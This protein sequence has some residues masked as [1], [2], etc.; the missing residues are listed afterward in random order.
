MRWKITTS[1]NTTCTNTE[2]VVFSKSV[3]VEVVMRRRKNFVQEYFLKYHQPFLVQ[4]SGAIQRWGFLSPRFLSVLQVFPNSSS[5]FCNG[6]LLLEQFIL[7]RGVGQHHCI[8]SEL[9]MVFQPLCVA[10]ETDRRNGRMCCE[11]RTVTSGLLPV[12][13]TL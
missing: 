11:L 5:L 9:M 7:S 10:S 1:C 12:Q 13:S 6:N 3:S 8:D 2:A 4:E